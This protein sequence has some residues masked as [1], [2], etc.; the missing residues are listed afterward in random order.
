MHASEMIRFVNCAGLRDLE[1]HVDIEKRLISVLLMES[2]V[3]S[4]LE[5]CRCRSDT[6][7]VQGN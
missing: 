1:R 6:E 3:S 7:P 4:G 2:T 5:S